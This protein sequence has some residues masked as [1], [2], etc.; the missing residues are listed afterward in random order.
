MLTRPRRPGGGG[1]VWGGVRCAGSV[2]LREPNLSF[3]AWSADF[4]ASY[5]CAAC[6]WARLG[7]CLGGAAVRCPTRGFTRTG[8]S[9][10]EE[11]S[12]S[13]LER[14]AIEVEKAL[15][16]V[17]VRT[18]ALDSAMLPNLGVAALKEVSRR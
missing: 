9:G 5:S 2:D 7:S 4:W 11:S 10:G 18:D 15:V 6:C 14:R 17:L 3:D 1:G 16:E 8:A 13:G 12:R